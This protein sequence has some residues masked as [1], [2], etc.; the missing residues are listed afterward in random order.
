MSC[1][2]CKNPRKASATNQGRKERG[3]LSGLDRKGERGRFCEVARSPREFLNLAPDLQKNKII[4]F[5]AITRDPSLF[6]KLDASFQS[7]R[8]FIHEA[9]K[10]HPEILLYVPKE[11]TLEILQRNKSLFIFASKE[12][13]TH[14]LKE[15]FRI[16]G[17]LTVDLLRKNRKQIEALIQILY[18]ETGGNEKDFLAFCEVVP[19]EIAQLAIAF[20]KVSKSPTV[21][22][23]LDP[24]FRDDFFIA[25]QAVGRALSCFSYV[26][27]KV[28]LAYVQKDKDR[29]FKLVPSSLQ[30]RVFLEESISFFKQNPAELL[31]E[32][33]RGYEEFFPQELDEIIYDCHFLPS[34]ETRI[35]YLTAKLNAYLEKENQAAARK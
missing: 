16:L 1:K 31:I 19:S 30:Y 12:V 20:F 21:F 23:D 9:L 10:L 7:D 34:K 4:A 17:L 25:S 18:Q 6:S 2:E 27:P 14:L 28:A 29:Y 26:G 35:Q 24:S 3:R 13:I 11:I 8:K 32:H 5:E 22:K 33:L 15:D